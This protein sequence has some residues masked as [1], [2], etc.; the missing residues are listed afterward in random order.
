MFSHLY[1]NF[2]FASFLL[3]ILEPTFDFV[4]IEL[5]YGLGMGKKVVNLKKFWILSI[6]LHF[7]MPLLTNDHEV[8]DAIICSKFRTSTSK[9]S[10]IVEIIN[11][12][13]PI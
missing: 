13:I 10:Q 1:S 4:A 9:I 5:D 12:E 11:I 7:S 6:G 8:I 2:S 3:V